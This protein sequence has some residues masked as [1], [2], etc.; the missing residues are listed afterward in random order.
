MTNYPDHSQIVIWPDV[1]DFQAVMDCGCLVGEGH[2]ALSFKISEGLHYVTK[3]GPANFAAATAQNLI[4]IPYHFIL[5]GNAAYQA[6]HVADLIHSYH[7]GFCGTA[8]MV[9]V[10]S[11]G[12]LRPTPADCSQF[13]QT[14][15][16]LGTGI[17]VG[18]YCAYWYWGQF[19]N[20]QS[21]FD[22][23]ITADYNY[24]TNNPADAKDP[25]WILEVPNGGVTPNYVGGA[26]WGHAKSQARQFTDAA[27]CAHQTLV[28][29]NIW[30]GTKDEMRK[31][32]TAAIPDPPPSTNRYK[33]EPEIKQGANDVTYP[34][35]V[36]PV[37]DLQNG[38]TA[39]FQPLTVDGVFGTKTDA[40]VR[41]FQAAALGGA[42]TVD[43]IVGPKTWAKLDLIL[44]WQ[45]K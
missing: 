44:D 40:V 33:N 12:S 34:V 42:L 7:G 4:P 36:H 18:G 25:W 29:C 30:W 10:E 21:P 22:W 2:G 28:D 35:G 11:D 17:P 41:A 14:W 6:K 37:K 24:A 26:A 38:L 9:D 16:S 27:L 45:G 5:P 43:G 23:N 13:V 8:L 1:S 39:A 31:A 3:T 32:V 19:G 20:P 15:H